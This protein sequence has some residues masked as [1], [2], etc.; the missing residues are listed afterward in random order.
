[1]QVREVM[2]RDVLVTSP[3][4]TIEKAA[5]L[6]GKVNCGALPVSENDRLV[7]MVTDRDITLRA[8]AKGNPPDH[9]TVREVMSPDIKY[10]FEDEATE[11][12]AESMSKL[13][14]R[15]LPAESAETLGRDCVPWR[16]CLEAEGTG[17]ECTSRNFKAE[18]HHPLTGVGEAEC[19]LPDRLHSPVWLGERT[20]PCTH[21]NLRSNANAA[22]RSSQ[23]S[24]PRLMYSQRKS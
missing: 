15:R 22:R 14:V 8:V 10:V 21:T 12:A 9:C 20:F 24:R 16:S 13:Q 1:M 2:S 5:T 23:N 4:D 11:A 3:D 19:Q 17:R 18:W 7:G 6:M